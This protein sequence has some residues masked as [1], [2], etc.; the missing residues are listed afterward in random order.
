MRERKPNATKGGWNSSDMER[1]VEDV[2]KNSV[3]ERT[4]ARN[5]GVSRSTLKRKLKEAR[6]NPEMR[7][8]SYEAYAHTSMKVFSDEEEQQ[9]VEY[10]ISASKMGYGLSSVKLRSLAFEFADKLDKRLP[11]SRQQHNPWSSNEKA[12][13][14]WMRAFMKRHPQLS[15]RKPDPTSIGRMSAFN[16]HNVEQ[17][18]GNI[19]RV[20]KNYKVEAYQMW[21]CDETGITTVQVP[22]RIIAQK[23]ERQVAAVTSAE[24]GTLVTMCNAVSASGCSIPPFYIFPRVNFRDV[25]LRNAVPG[26]AGA[27]NP[28]GWMIESTFVEW[29]DHFVKHVRPSQESPVLLVL[30]NH[31]THLSVAVI[32]KAKNHGVILV[33]IPPHT[34]HKLQPL[35]VSIYGPFKRLYNREMSAWL[36]SN[37]GKTVSIYE[38]AEISGKAWTKACV[39]SNIISGFQSAGI[40]PFQPDRWQDDDFSLAQV[41]DRPAPQ[42]EAANSASGTIRA[43]SSEANCD[44]STSSSVSAPQALEQVENIET[45]PPVAQLTNVETPKHHSEASTGRN[46]KVTPEA[47]RPFPKAPARKRISITGRRKLSSEILTSTPVKERLQRE[48]AERSK[49]KA[50]KRK[51]DDQHKQVTHDDN[52]AGNQKR[53]GKSRV[54]NKKG[55][56]SRRARDDSD[57]SDEEAEYYCLVCVE[58]YSNSRSREKWIQCITCKNWAHLAC[59]DGDK[60][61][62]CHHCLS[63]ND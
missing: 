37:P 20:L 57:D 14:D 59:T 43:T 1:A 15:I 34:S 22:E 39:P 26:A 56:Q 62:I 52:S 42:P 21:N 32:D 7:P 12:G 41:T 27:A 8:H 3:S 48:Q 60:Q 36:L 47:V 10:C 4:A 44:P 16:R 5:F 63:D 61:Y 38:L 33:T 25:F 46:D 29:F 54:N 13:N 28:S 35:D 9:L 6:R 53:K 11:H 58:P 45:E 30:D 24:R 2:L 40:Y 51:I 23:G 49:K 55:K 50:C 17:F 19:E 18:Y 31:E